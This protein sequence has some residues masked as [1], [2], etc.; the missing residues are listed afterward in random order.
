MRQFLKR[1]LLR[2]AK[3]CGLFAFARWRLRGTVAIIAWHGVSIGDEH[4]LF[5]DYFITPQTLSDRLAFLQQHFHIVSLDEAV[6]QL[7]LGQLAPRQVVL[8]FDDG[9][10]SF[11]T[12]AIPVLQRWQAP[13]TVYI[14]SSGLDRRTTALNMAV[15]ELL[16]RTTAVHA[17]GELFADQQARPIDTLAQ[18]QQAGDLAVAAMNQRAEY[19]ERIEFAQRVSTALGID[20]QRLFGDQHW[21]YMV[22][23]EVRRCVDAGYD[24]QLHSDLH[25][26]TVEMQDELLDD[27]VRC[28]QQIEAVTGRTAIDYCYPSGLWTRRCWPMLEQAG[29]RSAVTCR[30][31]PNF[32]DT[33]LLA[34][35]RYVDGQSISQLEFEALVSGFSWY[36]NW[37]LG[38]TDRSQPS[39]AVTETG[40]Y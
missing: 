3:A 9:D 35:R 14:V 38:R 15:R 32:P 29:V 31:G 16:L 39:E 2:V 4:E 37:W 25:R 34:L 21:D 13:A 30:L 36:V 22:A 27:T 26:T 24:M 33:P 28:R 8:T 11:L 7:Q 1:I 40:L 6:R 20:W 10:V 17:P 5:A 18:R 23:D 12:Q 19:A